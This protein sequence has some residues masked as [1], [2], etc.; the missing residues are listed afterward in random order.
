MAH[1]QSL[2]ENIYLILSDRVVLQADNHV[3]ISET[4]RKE[5]AVSP[6]TAVE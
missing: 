4:Q 1:E 6:N 3:L 2:G 5:F